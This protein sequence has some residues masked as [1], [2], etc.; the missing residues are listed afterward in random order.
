MPFI[1]EYNQK[2][3]RDNFREKTGLTKL[4][5]FYFS[6]LVRKRGLTP[7]GLPNDVFFL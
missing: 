2:K 7:D 6:K 1:I 5:H 3:C 4:I